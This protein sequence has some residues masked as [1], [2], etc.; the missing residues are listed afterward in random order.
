M[1]PQYNN[2]WKKKKKLEFGRVKTSAMEQNCHNQTDLIPKHT[3][4]S[5]LTLS[6]K[7]KKEEGK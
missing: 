7:S 1:Y 3:T 5:T 4:F 6:P 2:K